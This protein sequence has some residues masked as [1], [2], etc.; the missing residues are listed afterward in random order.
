MKEIEKDNIIFSI[1]T[2]DLQNIALQKIGRKLSKK[3]ITI[4]KKGLES[5]LLFDIYTV[6]EAIFSEIMEQ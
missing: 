2:E 6:Y 3:E 1:T 4:A 5:G